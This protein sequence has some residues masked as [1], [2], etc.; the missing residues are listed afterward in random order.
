MLLREPTCS[1]RCSS[2]FPLARTDGDREHAAAIAIQRRVRG[3][4]A[5][6]ACVGLAGIRKGSVA[7][8]V[9][10]DLQLLEKAP[11]SGDGTDDG[12]DKAFGTLRRDTF[13]SE[14]EE[15][16]CFL[17]GG[18]AYPGPNSGFEYSVQASFR[19]LVMK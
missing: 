3:R 11:S 6:K 14:E 1:N 10:E 17:I 4:Q 2:R 15:E 19:S 5:R 13:E 18:N 12:V 9:A 7:R 8:D 16:D